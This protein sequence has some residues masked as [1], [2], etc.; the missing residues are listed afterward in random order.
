M[1]DACAV[2]SQPSRVPHGLSQGVKMQRKWWLLAAGVAF[3]GLLVMLEPI[4]MP[5]F[6]GMIL[7]YLG[8]PLADW[9]EDKGL[10]RHLAVT[11]VFSVLSVV[12]LI[13]LLVLV[14][15]LGWCD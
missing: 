6:I 7:A 2:G 13:A 9:L 12:L 5:F 3:L 10:S 14:P 4:L 1:G 8:D 11:L 15:L